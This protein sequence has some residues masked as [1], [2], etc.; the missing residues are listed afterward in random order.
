MKVTVLRSRPMR[1]GNTVVN[2]GK[3]IT[4][5]DARL[6]EIQPLLDEGLVK[7]EKVRIAENTTIGYS[8]DDLEKLKMD[9]LREI[10]E[11]LGARDTKK[12]ELIDEI[13]EK[14]GG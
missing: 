12:S 9:E 8:R 14:Q 6:N 7:V 2:P 13:I 1:I 11:P 4:V 5:D 10:G 3:S